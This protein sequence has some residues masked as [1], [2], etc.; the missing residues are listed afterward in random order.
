[1]EIEEENRM[2]EQMECVSVL[3]AC[4]YGE[5]E[6]VLARVCIARIAAHS[7]NCNAFYF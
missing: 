5:C 6:C 4:A 3:D 1:M 2:L 7:V